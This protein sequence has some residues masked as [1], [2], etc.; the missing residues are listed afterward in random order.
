L[1][2]ALIRIVVYSLEISI[3]I[4]HVHDS[5]IIRTKKKEHKCFV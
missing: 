1:F 4:K 2:D 3:Y 5:I